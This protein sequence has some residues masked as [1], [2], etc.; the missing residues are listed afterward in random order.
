[1]RAT[2]CASSDPTPESL[3]K[4]ASTPAHT[5]G[6]KAATASKVP[7][8]LGLFQETAD[9]PQGDVA[10]ADRGRRLPARRAVPKSWAT[11]GEASA[12]MT[13]EE[14]AAVGN[15]MT[16]FER[17]KANDGTRTRPAERP[18]RGGTPGDA[19]A[20]AV[21]HATRRDLQAWADPACLDPQGGGRAEG[22]GH[23][24]T[25]STGLFSKRCIRS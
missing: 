1:M 17:V 10:R 23:T 19:A 15:L 11:T 5:G 13:M 21:P 25:W 14:V 22:A 20:A 7:K 6:G 24:P 4:G 16:A 3:R 9:S 12:A 18:R 8:Q 2:E